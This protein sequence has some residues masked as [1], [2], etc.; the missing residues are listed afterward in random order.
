MP[1]DK[2]VKLCYE[3][4]KIYDGLGY[5]NWASEVRVHLFSNGFGYVWENQRVDNPKLFLVQYTQRLKDQYI[6]EWRSKCNTMSKLCHYVNFKQN[7]DIEK[8]INA[9]DIEKFRT[10]MARYRS[11]SH[12]L[13]V[14]KCRYYG[15]YVEDRNCPYCECYLEDLYHFV[16]VCP[17]YN[18][19]RIKYISLEYYQAPNVQRFYNL[20]SCEN[21][22]TIRDL[23]MYLYFATKERSNFLS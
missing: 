16:L 23:A 22:K 13:M 1:S 20:M 6:Q 15:I 17:L 11:S 19:L 14:E 12:N 21:V 8:Y 9:I 4:L 18:D 7:Y 3:M 2:Y 10:C 5:E